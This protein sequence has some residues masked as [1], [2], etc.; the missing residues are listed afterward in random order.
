MKAKRLRRLQELQGEITE[1]K[2]RALIGRR[3]T[4]LAE[5]PG[6]SGPVE[7]TGRTECGRVVSFPAGR[8]EL[9]KGMMTDVLI[10]GAYQNSLRGVRAGGDAVCSWK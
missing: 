6:K 2:G 8:D 10:T 3:L 1:E 9:H 5:G 7:F 4:V